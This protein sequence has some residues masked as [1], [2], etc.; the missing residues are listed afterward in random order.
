MATRNIKLIAFAALATLG[1]AG[2]YLYSATAQVAA[3]ELAQAPLNI[4]K[5]IPPAFIMAVDNS[6]SMAFEMLFPGTDGQPYW[7][8]ATGGS[9]G[10]RCANSGTRANCFFDTSGNIRT[11]TGGPKYVFL[12]PQDVRSSSVGASGHKGVPP[13][14]TFG[15]ARSHQFNPAYFNPYPAVE[16]LPWK[17][18]QGANYTL[19]TPTDM[20]F[21]PRNNVDKINLTVVRYDRTDDG[22]DTAP[23]ANEMFTMPTGAVLPSGSI[24]Y[25]TASCGGLGASA[26]TRNTWV[27]TS[28]DVRL[29]ATCDIGIAFFPAVFYLK[30]D[31]AV[32][33]GFKSAVVTM[34]STGGRSLAA[35]ACGDGCDMYRYEI[36][37]ENYDSG[38]NAAIQKFASWLHFYGNRDKAVIAAMTNALNDVSKMRVGHFKIH[39]DQ[40]T[41]SNI[42]NIA[43]YNMA[44]EADRLNLYQDIAKRHCSGTGTG[45]GFSGTSLSPGNPCADAGLYG[46]TPNHRAVDRMGAQFKR[47]DTN[48][49]VLRACQKNA[50]MLFT[51][52]F[53]N[54][55]YTSTNFTG[56]QDGSSATPA[57]PF[58]DDTSGKMSDI[59]YHYYKTPLRTGTGWEGEVPVPS[60]CWLD[61]EEMTTLDPNRD[62][63]LD[64]QTD[65]HMNFYGVTLGTVGNIYNAPDDPPAWNTAATPVTANSYSWPANDRDG[66]RNTID[67]LWQATL[68]TRGDFINATTPTDI[69][70]AMRK[71]LAS[72]GDGNSPAGGLALTGSRIGTGS[73][74]VTPSY[75]AESQ[76]SAPPTDWYG[77]LLA[78]TI[79]SNPLTGQVT[80]TKAW[81]ANEELP[82]H[83][84]RNIVF[85]ASPTSIAVT[86][87]GFESSH[88]S[89]TLA[90]LCADDLAPVLCAPNIAGLGVSL[91]EAVNYLRGDRALE[92]TKLRTRTKVLG[93][94]INSTPVVT[95]GRTISSTPTVVK[96]VDDYGYRSLGGTLATSYAAY[97]A[98]KRTSGK[99]MVYVGANDGML[100]AFDGESGE[101]TFAYIPA[102]SLGHMGNLLFPYKAL[103]GSLQKFDHR[104]YV[105]GPITISDVYDG[106]AWKTVLV[107]T[108]G[109]GGRSVFALDITD[110]DDISVLWEV[111][112]LVTGNDTVADNIGYVLGKPVIVPVRGAGGEDPTW[113]V[114]FGNGYNSANQAPALF[115]VDAITGSTSVIAA[116]EDPDGND[117]LGYNGLGNIVVVDMQRRN[118]TGTAWTAGRDGSADTVYAGDQNGAVWKF[119]L[120][121]AAPAFGDTPFFIARDSSGTRQPITGGLE[122]AAGPGTASMIFFG[123]G[124]FSFEGDDDLSSTQSFYAIIDRGSAV[125]D[126][127]SNLLQ[128][129]AG[130]L[131][132][133]FLATSSNAITGADKGWYIDLAAGERMV[134]N[135]RV[136]SGIIFFPTYKPPSES[137]DACGVEG[138][139]FLYGLNA[140][141]GAA[142]LTRVH[143]GSP[144]G[145]TPTSATGAIKLDTGGTAPVTDVAVMTTP[146][147]SA[148]DPDD[149]DDALDARCSMVVQ[150]AG[151]E[152]MYLPRPCGRQSWRQVR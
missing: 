18:A 91:A 68:N 101:E 50:G 78:Q 135:P 96:T 61:P 141:S 33:T 137:G 37:P 84:S 139:N 124:S 150:V 17:T 128:Q 113:K 89:L 106:S 54:Q 15:F 86:E 108:S 29:S 21:D 13:I 52:G 7:D 110:P 80:M 41:E 97:L 87:A 73:L 152:P 12:F 133:I 130:T 125:E 30:T 53:A 35:N 56:N 81:E 151:A 10:S 6:G 32:P 131:S 67:G 24:Y 69:T 129:T 92:G 88:A 90:K 58:P 8:T 66:S 19:P 143:M 65:P 34:G 134:G 46:G 83:G 121:S 48:A 75:T 138:E 140:L 14:P 85:N 45:T 4:S 72:I 20:T 117:L 118:Y 103:D 42:T 126:G 111:S 115:V 44:T 64:C 16:Y 49:P 23:S 51:D 122:A 62:P 116:A 123:T 119:D 39:Y 55:A 1:G 25:T 43:M 38:Y 57:P 95:A 94:I 79:T 9:A 144:D 77:E 3:P 112:D 98:T 11:S 27:T 114:V 148:A 70:E 127:R 31:A 99:Q 105:D 120:H 149:L 109:A 146:R 59:A 147:L 40:R 22:A 145:I 63:R 100:H 74:S 136:E 71:I 104:Y 28:A 82:A 2:Y 107:G 142:A 5:S 26:A 132:G 60:A 47:T 76:G 36:R 102:T 93:D